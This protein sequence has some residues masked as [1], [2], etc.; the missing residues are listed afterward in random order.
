MLEA[1]RDIDRGRDRARI[2]NVLLCAEFSY[3]LLTASL[4]AARVEKGDWWM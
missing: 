2:S 3:A 1:D 4:P